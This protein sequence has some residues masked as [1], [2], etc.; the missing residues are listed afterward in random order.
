[1]SNTRT[2]PLGSEQVEEYNRN[3]FIMGG[4]VISDDKVAQLGAS[5]ERMKTHL[6]EAN[7]MYVDLMKRGEGNKDYAFDYFAFLWKKHDEFMEVATS[8]LLAEMVAQL[9]GTDKVV[10]FGDAAF[11]KPPR[12]G[13][14]LH[15]HQDA[16][17]WPL[18]EPGGLTCWIA[19]DEV[20]PENGSMSFAAGSHLLGE[21]LPV[22]ATTGE[23][24]Y[25]SY[26]GGETDKAG[27][28]AGRDLSNSGLLPVTTPEAAGLPEVPTFYEPGACSFHDSLVWH[29]SGFNTSENWRRSYSIRYVDGHRIWLG[30]QKAFYYFHDDEVGVEPG[31]PVG[32]PNF[33]T[34]WDISA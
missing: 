12:K 33:P 18:D 23:T 14:Q 26:A 17:A 7:S 6:G 13:G 32:G 5:L 27:A 28:F 8:P 21:R 31:S 24:L 20:T 2:E 30:E 19:L 15:W 9:L 16:M 11:L 34:V 3:G 4:K 22:E 10:L 1:M 25:S 29:A